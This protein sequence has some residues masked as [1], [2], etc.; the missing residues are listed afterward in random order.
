ML[1]I[2]SRRIKLYICCGRGGPAAK[3]Q[4]LDSVVVLRHK[5]SHE[6]TQVINKLVLNVIVK[7]QRPLSLVEDDSFK[8]LLAYLEPGYTLPGR[9]HFT[10]ALCVRYAEVQQKLVSMLSNVEFVSITADTWTSVATESYLTV[11]VHYISEDWLLMSH[12]LGTLPL[13]ERHTGENLAAWMIEMLLKFDVNPSKVV[14][15]VHDNASNM[16]SATNILLATYGINSLRCSAHTLQLVVHSTLNKDAT[17]QTTLTLAR[18]LVEHFRR[19]T[20]ANSALVQQQEQMNLQPLD[21]IQDVPT[22]WSS[23]YNMCKR[24]VELRLPVSM[25]M[26]NQAIIEKQKRQNLELSS[27]NWAVL[28]TLCE[29]LEPFAVLTKYLEGQAYVSVSAIQ[30][31]LKGVIGAMKVEA[32][33]THYA[34]KFKEAAVEELLSR[35]NSLFSPLP[36]DQS[37][38]PMALRGS[39]LDIRFHKLKSLAGHQARTIRTAIESE[40]VAYG[41]QKANESVSAVVN[42]PAV[43]QSD[44]DQHVNVGSLLSY[45]QADARPEDDDY[46]VNEGNAFTARSVRHQMA[47]FVSQSQQPHDT[48]P[49][50]WWKKNELR[51]KSLSSAARKYLAIPATSAPSERVF[52]IAGN[53]C[54]RRR[55]SL[56]P[57]HLDSLVFLNA[58]AELM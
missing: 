52:S 11:T 24:L 39:A 30:P 31:L 26:A 22:R 20:V 16:V 18:K 19:S 58:N 45:L 43:S 37:P 27:E 13:E 54:N 29:L 34:K 38:I 21:L 12:V 57:D 9:K 23:T 6:K 47:L 25:V 7:G 5:T 4:R 15:V 14:T 32:D 55:A 28:E 2:C 17:V 48:D 40:I 3:Q 50:Q 56:S 33:D 35:F 10:T 51:F 41:V 49:L 44:A 53:I 36:S 8:E 46:V 1:Q 42:L